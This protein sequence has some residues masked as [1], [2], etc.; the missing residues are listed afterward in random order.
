M[1]RR[2]PLASAFVDTLG[3]VAI[4]FVIF[5]AVITGLVI[6]I[7]VQVMGEKRAN[8][9]AIYERQPRE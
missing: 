7:V 3:L 4:F 5:P 8:Q 9:E 6:M 2:V 1:L